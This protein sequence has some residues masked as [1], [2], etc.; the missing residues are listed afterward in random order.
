MHIHKYLVLDTRFCNMKQEIHQ[1]QDSKELFCYLREFLS[2][3]RFADFFVTVV[4][5]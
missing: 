5:T 4:P 3:D 1:K 2:V